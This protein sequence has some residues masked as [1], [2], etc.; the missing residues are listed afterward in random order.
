MNEY[1]DLDALTRKTRRL[2]FDDG[3]TDLQN[4]LVFLFLG[5]SGAFFMPTAGLMLYMRAILYNEELTIVALIGLIALVVLITFGLRR[6]IERYRKQV[7][8]K[9]MGEME[10]FRWQVDRRASVLATVIWLVVLITGL[11]LFS[12]D[13]MDLD[14][15]M[16]VIIAAGGVATGVVYFVMGRSLEI[17]RYLWVAIIGGSLSAAIMVL[18][19]NTGISWLVFGLIWMVTLLV[20][21]VTALRG[22]LLKLQEGVS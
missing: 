16:R 13:P 19:F 3:L 2:E 12:S 22:T 17:S 8:W 7:L 20:S 11:A 6:L 18:P 10:P 4:S 9:D 15:G 21:G 14:A 5:L 1:V